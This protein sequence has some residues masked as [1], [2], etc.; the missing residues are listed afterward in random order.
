MEHGKICSKCERNDPFPFPR[1]HNHLKRSKATYSDSPSNAG[2]SHQ[3]KSF[4][5]KKN[6]MNASP[7]VSVSAS[8]RKTSAM[9]LQ[10]T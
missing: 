3:Y 2:T 6:V 8:T 10:Q 7:H 5:T 9:I 4:M 1:R